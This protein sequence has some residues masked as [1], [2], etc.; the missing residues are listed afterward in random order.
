MTRVLAGPW[1]G[2][3][4]A[5]LGADVIK[6]ERPGKG[7]DSRAFAPP[8]IKD[9]D[10][11]D[12]KESAYFCCANR[13]KRSVT[14]DIS[15]PEG[16]QL[17]RDL[18]AKVDVLLENYKFGDLERYGLGYEQLKAINPRLIYCSVTGFGQTGPDREKP[19]YDFMIQ[20]MGGIMSVTGERNGG[21]QRVGI[22]IADIMT[23]MYSS[24]AVCAAIA[25]RAE[26]G[27][28]QHVDLALLD[29]Q[30]AVLAYQA[31][32]YL[33]TGVPPGRTGN[34]HP[35]IVPYQPFPTAD[36]DVIIACGNDNLFKKFCEVA[37]CTHLLQDPRFA[38]NADRVRN[39]E[40]I[41][42]I[43]AEIMSKRT[44]K[45]WVSAL[46]AAGVPCGPINN[47]KEVF[48]EPQVKARGMLQ[49]LPH[50]SAGK[51]PQVVSPMKFS[52]TPLEFSSA[53]P[54][55]GEHT[56]QVLRE[57]LGRSE[58]DIAALRAAK[59]I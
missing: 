55:L 23:G 6:I 35:N 12:T 9:A 27:K 7:D 49:E 22:P 45:A 58:A 50:A 43:V 40:Q 44:T 10:G 38:T 2:Q 36:G 26:T 14:V 33:S 5:D 30:V 4:L 25:H 57:V 11:N 1:T 41:E 54:V 20:G 42:P 51:V 56:D 37:A 17:V 29:C 16:A 46:E 52:G 19:G 31:M 32:N 3:N 39:R 18:A 13:G 21:P 28:G 24:I 47:L 15:K 8:Y 53:P 59:A 34:V 48:E